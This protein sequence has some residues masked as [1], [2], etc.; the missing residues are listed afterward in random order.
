MKNIPECLYNNDPLLRAIQIC[1]AGDLDI[2][3]L[4]GEGII[5]VSVNQR[6]LVDGEI[7]KI[8]GKKP[9]SV[10][11]AD[12]VVNYYAPG[13]ATVS[14]QEFSSTRVFAPFD[15]DLNYSA[16]CLQLLKTATEKL[17]LDNCQVDRI[18]NVAI[19]CALLS[20]RKS[21]GI[22][23]LAEAIHY[24]LHDASMILEQMCEQQI[25]IPVKFKIINGKPYISV[26]RNEF[27]PSDIMDMSVVEFFSRYK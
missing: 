9:V 10:Y 26:G 16:G 14:R 8:L 4:Y 21:I 19:T 11:D 18:K 23:D 15:F 27:T 5:S 22:E 17:S 2:G 25:T 13:D 12:V 7:Q 24:Q 1:I 6:A 3:I 20:G